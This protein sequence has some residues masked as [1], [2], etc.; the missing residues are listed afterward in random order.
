MKYKVT[1][2]EQEYIIEV[3]TME[4]NANGSEST[5]ITGDEVSLETVR[6][7][8]NHCFERSVKLDNKVYILLTACA[9]LFAMLTE[10]I[11]K[12]N[13]FCL[14]ISKCQLIGE[15]IYVAMLTAVIIVYV[16]VVVKL[17][18]LLPGIRLSRFDSFETLEKN[19][20]WSDKKQTIKYI[21]S[22][23]EQCRN[24]NNELIEQQYKRFNSCVK[25]LIVTVVLL[26]VTSVYGCIV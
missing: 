14:P 2:D 18:Q 3:E 7:E 6:N 5:I 4:E 17:L 10:S 12:L 22:R 19:M 20:I 16:I 9:F 25:L 24:D 15:G 1:T 11:K 26:L 21:C 13:T 8:Y 23:Y